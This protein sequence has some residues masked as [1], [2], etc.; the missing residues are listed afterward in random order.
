L[1]GAD[2]E[3]AVL[4]GANF[5]EADLRGTNFCRADVSRVNFSDAKGLTPELLKDACVGPAIDTKN[6]D[7]NPALTVIEDAQPFGMEAV[8]G[9]NYRVKRC[10]SDK[11]CPGK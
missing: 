2:F 8:V 7:T 11:I 4:A 6:P 5:H 10:L 3:G 9:K 1:Q